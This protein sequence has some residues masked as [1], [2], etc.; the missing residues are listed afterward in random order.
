[1]PLVLGLVPRSA[2]RARPGVGGLLGSRCTRI[3]AE[4]TARRLS[5]RGAWQPATA[6][7]LPSYFPNYLASE[8]TSQLQIS[9]I[10]Q[11]ASW[12]TQ[13]HALPQ[14]RAMLDGDATA[15]A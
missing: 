13:H 10:S 5:A 14:V 12:L 4:P 8:V 7:Y 15:A 2:S 9:A 1:M 11:L 6:A 3:A